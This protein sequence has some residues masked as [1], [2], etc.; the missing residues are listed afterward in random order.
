MEEVIFKYTQEEAINDGVLFSLETVINCDR[1]PFNVVTNSLMQKGYFSDSEGLNAPALTD[2][3]KQAFQIMKKKSK[4][5]TEEDY[6]FE[7]IVE[8]PNGLKQK[9]FICLNETGKFTLMLPEDY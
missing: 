2:L 4:D 1:L 5:F 9:I 3:L 6:F 8:L 7:G